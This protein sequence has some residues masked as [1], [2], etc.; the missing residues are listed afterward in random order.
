[1]K[2]HFWIYIWVPLILGYSPL[3]FS[4]EVPS[5]SFYERSLAY[6]LDQGISATGYSFEET[7][8]VV[9]STPGLSY[10]PL[11]VGKA[12]VI[13]EKLSREGDATHFAAFIKTKVK[14]WG[15]EAGEL[16][17]RWHPSQSF[18]ALAAGLLMY[19][20]DRA[21]P[22]PQFLMDWFPEWFRPDIRQEPFELEWHKV[23]KLLAVKKQRPELQFLVKV[24]HEMQTF[25]PEV[26]DLSAVGMVSYFGDAVSN[27]TIFIFEVSTDFSG[28]LRCHQQVRSNYNPFAKDLRHIQGRLKCDW[29]EL[30]IDSK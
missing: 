18:L 27:K 15:D 12:L 9:D 29:P 2:S 1:M 7:S 30:N 16:A 22:W 5:L 21:Y 13:N 26:D 10:G 24:I 11:T 19:R 6:L 8:V 20:M 23:T 25:H 4:E 14:I 17:V 28:A 3:I